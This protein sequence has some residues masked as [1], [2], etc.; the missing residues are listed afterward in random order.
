MKLSRRHMIAVTA[1]ALG[2]AGMSNAHAAACSMERVPTGAISGPPEYL[3]GS[4]VRTSFLT[5]H[6][7]GQRI[8]LFGRALTTTCEP[9]ASARLDF[10]HSDSAGKYDEGHRFRGIQ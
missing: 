8:K 4:P 1:S 9:L 2:A 3:P 5:D 7:E 6:G 10:W